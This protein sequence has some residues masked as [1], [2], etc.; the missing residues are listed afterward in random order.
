MVIENLDGY[1]AVDGP[2]TQPEIDVD[3]G[4]TESALGN[5]DQNKS[6]DGPFTHH[7]HLNRDDSSTRRICRK[8][9]P[10]GGT[11]PLTVYGTRRSIFP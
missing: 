9:W 6:E 2:A 11:F 4:L 8:A 10:E 5:H 3:W 1:S 7:K